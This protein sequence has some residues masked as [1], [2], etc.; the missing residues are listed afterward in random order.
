M[1]E[2]TPELLAKFDKE[3]QIRIVKRVEE[4]KHEL[5][6]YLATVKDETPPGK[7]C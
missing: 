1:R 7:N 3:T 6:V 2:V 4:L 5:A